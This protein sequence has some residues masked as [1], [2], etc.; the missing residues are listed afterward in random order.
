MV[1]SNVRE[2]NIALV[3]LSIAGRARANSSAVFLAVQSK[4]P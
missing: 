1:V 3:C 4:L 2:A